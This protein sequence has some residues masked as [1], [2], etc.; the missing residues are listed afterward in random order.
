MTSTT[1]S[2]TTRLM[3]SARVRLPRST[4]TLERAFRTW[5]MIEPGCRSVLQRC[6][7][8]LVAICNDKS[9]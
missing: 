6:A 7:L 8:P 1:G 9:N 2:A 4:L 3:T 5:C